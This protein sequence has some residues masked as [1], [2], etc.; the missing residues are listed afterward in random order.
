MTTTSRRIRSLVT[1]V[2]IGTIAA[3]A[4]QIP[5]GVDAINLG[6]LGNW[7]SP[8]FTITATD[9]IDLGGVSSSPK[10][11]WLTVT[12]SRDGVAV[13]SF[14]MTGAS[15]FQLGIDGQAHVGQFVA[16]DL[17][18]PQRSFA[19]NDIGRPDGGYRY[20]AGTL[21]ITEISFGEGAWEGVT[22]IV[23]PVTRLRATVVLFTPDA[24]VITGALSI[25]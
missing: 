7:A 17:Q 23:R 2:L 9:D 13:A 8:D 21:D 6:S 18:Q 10:G 14:V 25:G 5:P 22:H 3:C 1:L 20:L 11:T 24:G 16:P 4:P 15:F 19:V 12:A